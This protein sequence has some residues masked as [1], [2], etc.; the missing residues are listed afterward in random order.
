MQLSETKTHTS[1]LFLPLIAS[2]V[3]TWLMD[4]A[5]GQNRPEQLGSIPSCIYWIII[6]ITG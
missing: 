3:S 1:S 4:F 6:T 2:I 5:E